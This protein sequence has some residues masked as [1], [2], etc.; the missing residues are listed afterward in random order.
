[1]KAFEPI[2][3]IYKNVYVLFGGEVCAREASESGGGRGQ[4]PLVPLLPRALRYSQS[5]TAANGFVPTIISCFRL[6][7]VAEMETYLH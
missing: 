4:W 6:H 2:V 3:V 5:G 7:S 1:M